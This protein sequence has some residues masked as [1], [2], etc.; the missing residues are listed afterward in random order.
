[1]RENTIQR[2]PEYLVQKLSNQSEKE[3]LAAEN[4]KFS[5]DIRE[6]KVFT[7]C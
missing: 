7:S 3:A 4:I 6:L 1:M 2:K 5:L